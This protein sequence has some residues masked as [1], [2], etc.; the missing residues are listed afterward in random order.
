MESET[1]SSS[2]RSLI[3]DDPLVRNCRSALLEEENIRLKSAISSIRE[4]IASSSID[5]SNSFELI[6]KIS[7][8]VNNEELTKKDTL[9][10]R[11]NVL[12]HVRAELEHERR[13]R[14]QEALDE[15][16]RRCYQLGK[17][18]EHKAANYEERFTEMESNRGT[19]QK[20]VDELK[21]EKAKLRNRIKVK[22]SEL[23]ESEVKSKKLIRKADEFEKLF[24]GQLECVKVLQNDL[25]LAS[26]ENK[27]LVNEMELLNKIFNELER[28]HVTE[29][30]KDYKDKDS[31]EIALF[32]N[33]LLKED[34]PKEKPRPSEDPARACF[35]EV[36]TKN[37]TRMVLSVSKTFMKLQDLILEKK[38]LEDEV[39]KM[40]NINAHLANKVNL[41]EAKLFNITDELNKTWNYVSTLKSQHSQ[42]HTSELILR[43][44]LA[45]KRNLLVKLREEL[46]YSRQSWNIVKQKTA[47]SERE[48]R[49]LRD[50]FAAR[51]LAF[52][53]FQPTGYTSSESGY[54]DRETPESPIKNKEDELKKIECLDSSETEEE[55]AFNSA[56]SESTN[57]LIL[58][59]ESE[60]LLPTTSLVLVPGLNYMAE[61]PE[62]LMPPLLSSEKDEDLYEKMMQST[63]RSAALANR[64]AEIH[65]SSDESRSPSSENEE[66]GPEEEEEGE[67]IQEE[68]DILLENPFGSSESL[69]AYIQK[70]GVEAEGRDVLLSESTTLTSEDDDFSSISELEEEE[71]TEDASLYEGQ[72]PSASALPDRIPPPILAHSLNN[73]SDDD[74]SDGDD[75]GGDPEG[76]TEN[77]TTVTRFLIKHLPKQL[78]QLRMDKMKLEEKVRGLESRVSEQNGALSELH[79]RNDLIQMEAALKKKP[80]KGSTESVQ[81]PRED[82]SHL[83]ESQLIWTVSKIEGNVFMLLSH[84]TEENGAL[85]KESV[86]LSNVSPS[87]LTFKDNE[88]LICQIK[89]QS[90]RRS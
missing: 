77:A 74:D 29:A 5:T 32:K 61:V 15:A 24:N 41:H 50:E 33:A 47:E 58:C 22:E 66:E 21:E 18:L 28:T 86:V 57:T 8:I 12:S 31:P 49:S 59:P 3:A 87:I 19:L 4:A 67:D 2:D 83:P 46:E 13:I 44:E 10:R 37:G 90:D 20:D 16:E 78:S 34:K 62:A 39:E 71:E 89:V 48:W 38:T 64:L 70:R 60:D 9:L 23:S 11:Q 42:L 55:D 84:S 27:S 36:T 14:T 69:N 73:L 68:E 43:A 75:D 81:S 76:L 17:E 82:N 54:S 79:R 45:E 56:M 52:K 53:P 40:K 65:R 35:K 85:I 1:S 26:T 30:L 51:R 6:E 72:Q 80:S 7:L 25:T 63:N 88:R